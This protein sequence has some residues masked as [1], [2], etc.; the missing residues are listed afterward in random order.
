MIYQA[1][2][3]LCV[4]I[5][6]RRATM[7]DG[8]VREGR[9]GM[10]IHLS[11]MK[12]HSVALGMLRTAALC[13]V[14]GLV[15]PIVALACFPADAGIPL[16]AFAGFAVACD[17]LMSFCGARVQ[18][19]WTGTRCIVSGSPVSQMESP[20]RI[21]CLVAAAWFAYAAFIS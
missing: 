9:K 2:Y 11:E 19:V 17:W 6:L 13:A 14:T 1:V 16:A 5:M 15:P 3:A 12:S 7:S 20:V 4:L 21:L 18:V 10:D 8:F